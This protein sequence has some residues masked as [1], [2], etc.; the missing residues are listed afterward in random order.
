MNS[1]LLIYLSL[2]SSVIGLVMVYIA[3]D[4][5]QLPA[6]LIGKIVYDDIGKNV[7]VC[8]EV[9]SFSVSKSKHVFFDIVDSSGRINAVVFNSSA[10]KLQAY[11][12]KDDDAICVL[13]QVD[14]Y[15]GRLEILPKE[16]VR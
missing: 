9:D 8:G 15:D 4:N 6:V 5:I 12:L 2:A 13:G 10:E 7:K 11:S 3:A 1:R 14:E 16:I